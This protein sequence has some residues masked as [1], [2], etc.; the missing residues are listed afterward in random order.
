MGALSRS[1][2]AAELGTARLSALEA[3]LRTM[4]PGQA[5]RLDGPGW[6]GP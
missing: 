5:F 4:A 2:W 6:L 1:R 3:D